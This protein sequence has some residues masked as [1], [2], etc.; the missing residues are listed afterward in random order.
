MIERYLEQLGNI[1]DDQLRQELA[2]INHAAVGYS[3]GLDCS[4][5]A[6]LGAKYTSIKLYVVGTETSKDIISAEKGAE[7]FN[8][9]IE[10]IIITKTTIE[11][12]LPHIID[13]LKSR[14]AMEISIELALYFL[15]KHIKE[16]VLL[17]GQG[18]DEL[19]GG[20]SRYLRMGPEEREE[21]MR[22]D[23][24][25]YLHHHQGQER[26]LVGAFKKKLVTVYMNPPTVEFVESLPMEYKVHKN[27]R[28][29]ILKELGRHLGLPSDI[30][31]KPKKAVQY[32]SGILSL[33]KDL[34][35]EEGLELH[36][37]LKTL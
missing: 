28:K 6:K 3:G 20:Y 30:V 14:N 5:I 23:V 27:E 26:R 18:A 37:Y 19:F 21:H 13:I 15:G 33:L 22:H 1:L 10:K 8:L 4:V 35:K 17:M 12:S 25:Q 29:F 9:P 32:G 2:G 34:S 16:E 36:E 24:K 11:E 31:D 7:I